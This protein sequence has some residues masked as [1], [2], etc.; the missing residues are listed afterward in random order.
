MSTTLSNQRRENCG[1]AAE[2]P[3]LAAFYSLIILFGVQAKAMG[4]LA[5]VKAMFLV[6]VAGCILQPSRASK[7]QGYVC[8]TWHVFRSRISCCVQSFWRV[9]F[10]F[11]ADYDAS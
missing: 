2:V 5:L 11:S 3:S 1:F 6:F 9:S 8:H 4:I 7:P 10:Q